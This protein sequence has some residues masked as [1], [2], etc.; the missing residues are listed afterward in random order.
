[1]PHISQLRIAEGCMS[2]DRKKVSKIVRKRGR[3]QFKEG[4]GIKGSNE[5]RAVV[6]QSGRGGGTIC[7]IP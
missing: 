6:S 2:R 3:G 5:W 1:M 7:F 4:F